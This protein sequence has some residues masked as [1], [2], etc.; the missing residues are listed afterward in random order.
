MLFQVGEQDPAAE[1]VPDRRAAAQGLVEIFT[2]AGVPVDE[3]I[4]LSALAALAGPLQLQIAPHLAELRR[5]PTPPRRAPADLRRL[6]ETCAASSLLVLDA[7]ADEPRVF[8]H[9]WTATE[10]HR[11]WV[12]HGQHDQL[13]DAHLRA[14]EYWQW[15]VRVWPQDR[16]RD[17]E[18]LLEAR[19]HLL[20]AGRPD[21]A[22]ALTE[23][24]CSWL[25]DW[26]AW[27]RE[28]ALIRDTLAHLPGHLGPPPL[29]LGN[30]ARRHSGRPWAAG[31]G[32]AAVFNCR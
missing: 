23:I 15:R 21:A 10:L 28:E 1:H 9:R 12:D 18:N 22:T 8:V 20:A 27:D 26:C 30:P 4:D 25:H 19:H 2:T 13:N 11:R 16:Q 32:G 17:L 7:S 29:C 24:V 31:G 5:L 6:I 14:V 3:G